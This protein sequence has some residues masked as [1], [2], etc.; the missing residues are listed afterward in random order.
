MSDASFRSYIGIFFVGLTL[1]GGVGLYITPMMSEIPR[2]GRA[3]IKAY[4]KGTPDILLFGDSVMRATRIKRC[5][6]GSSTIDTLLAKELPNLNWVASPYSASSMVVFNDLLPIA[7]NR[8]NPPEWIIVPVNMRSFSEEWG[9]R[10]AYRLDLDR[11]LIRIKFGKVRLHDYFLV[12]KYQFTKAL[13]MEMEAWRNQ[14]VAYPDF[15]LGPRRKLHD[16]SMDLPKNLDCLPHLK[17]QYRDVLRTKFIYHYLY[18]LDPENPLLQSLREIIHSVQQSNKNILIYVTPINMQDGERFVGH[19]F[20]E[21]VQ[22]NVGVIQTLVENMGV[23]LLN[24]VDKL[25]PEHFIDQYAVC[26]H[27]DET[28]RRFVAAQ[29]AK[30]LR[31]EPFKKP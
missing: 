26:E 12:W 7:M 14:T 17:E 19:K 11:A 22:G 13:D 30:V 28:G 15:N 23:P 29:L 20:R 1:I 2:V 3:L 21:I 4:G 5:D 25:P 31:S 10:P 18:R 16:K 24:M 9:T 27:L 6:T 8:P